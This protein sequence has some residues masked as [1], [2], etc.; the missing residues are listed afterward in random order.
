MQ[1]LVA[2]AHDQIVFPSNF[3]LELDLSVLNS[4]QQLHAVV[5]RDF[6]VKAPSGTD[7]LSR[8]PTPA[9]MP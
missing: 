3:I 8:V 9:G 7:I 4:L 6:E 2:N 5:R 1:P